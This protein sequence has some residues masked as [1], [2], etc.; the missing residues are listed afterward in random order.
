MNMIARYQDIQP[1]PTRTSR[2]KYLQ[3]FFFFCW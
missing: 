3:Y 1:G 2:S